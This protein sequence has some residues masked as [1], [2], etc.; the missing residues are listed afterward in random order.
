MPIKLFDEGVDVVMPVSALGK[1]FANKAVY[2]AFDAAWGE[3][4]GE[5]RR[6]EGKGT[7]STDF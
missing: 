2:R 7:G 4:G 3:G 1:I 5:M 6:V